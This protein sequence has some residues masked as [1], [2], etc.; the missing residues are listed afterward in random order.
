MQAQHYR[1]LG[2][3]VVW[4]H[5]GAIPLEPGDKII[6]VPEDINFVHLPYPDRVWTNAFD[7][8]YQKN[9]NFK[10]HPGTYIQVADGCW[11]AKCSFC[12]EKKRAWRVR[13]IWDVHQELVSIH[14]LGFK[15]VF[16]DSGTFPVGTWLEN[17]LDIPNPGIT[18][19]CNMRMV[20]APWKRMKDWGFRMVLFGLESANQKTLDKIQKGV[21]CEDIK[22]V[23]KASE[24]G[25]DP[26]IAVMF[27]YPWESDEDSKRTLNLVH[28]LL[29]NGYAKT[30]QASFYEPIGETGSRDDRERHEKYVTRIYNVA[31]NPIFWIKKIMELK[32]KEDIAYLFRQIRE[33][34]FHG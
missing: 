7:K 17:F 28:Y 22:N 25:L 10:F 18:F 1:N 9:G 30:A 20:D 11:W 6:S 12:V 19:G 27:G 26:H 13:P 34:L 14:R 15:E 24:A 5:K 31:F 16:D 29:K 21:K 32:T 23:I 33:G 2:H 3:K 8:R 4:D